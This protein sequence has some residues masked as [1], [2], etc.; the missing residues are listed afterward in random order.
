MRLRRPA[1]VLAAGLLALAGCIQVPSGVTDRSATVMRAADRPVVRSVAVLPVPRPKG[2]PELASAIEAALAASLRAE[3]APARVVDAQ[4]FARALGR[5]RGYV[6]HFARWR[7]AYE[8]TN[9]L[10]RRPLPAY[11]RASGVRHLLLVRGARLDRDPLDWDEVEALGCCFAK[12]GSRYWRTRLSVAAE[13]VDAGTGR[14][15]WR[16]RGEA[17]RLDQG[18]G[19]SADASDAQR[20]APLVETAAQG[21]ARQIGAAPASARAR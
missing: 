20:M 17:E 2:P 10:D 15:V 1:R 7:A 11:A 18:D 8:K 9:A 21:L 19:R 12:R 6:Q 3:F 5:H 4:D 13:L 14:V 16:G